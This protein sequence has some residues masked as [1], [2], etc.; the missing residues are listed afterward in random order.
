MKSHVGIGGWIS[1]RRPIATPKE[2]EQGFNGATCIV[3]SLLQAGKFNETVDDLTKHRMQ[4][5]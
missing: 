2:N 3:R 1:Q 4:I 5:T